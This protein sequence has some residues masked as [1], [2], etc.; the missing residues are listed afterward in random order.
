MCHE[1]ADT[2]D[3]PDPT[4]EERVAIGDGGVPFYWFDTKKQRTA[5]IRVVMLPDMRGPHAFYMSLAG[6]LADEGI[7]TA[8]LDYL[9]R[10]PEVDTNDL[11]AA[12]MRRQAFDLSKGLS[13]I[14]SCLRLLKQRD[15]APIVVMGFCLGG[16]LAMFAQM[17]ATVDGS[18]I[19]YG[20]PRLTRPTSLLEPYSVLDVLSAGAPLLGFWGEEEKVVDLKSVEELDRKLEE[21]GQPHQIVRY[22][23]VGHAFL[24]FDPNSSG[25]PASADSWIKSMQFLLKLSGE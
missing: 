23:G 21:L 8:L 9:W 14:T 17:E 25:Y 2:K 10:L 7:Q 6:R 12:R 18:I 16:T 13:D 15:A 1:P 4:R 24:T 19:Y 22:P 5:P 11:E 20:L 3:A